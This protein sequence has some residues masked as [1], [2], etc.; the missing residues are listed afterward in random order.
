MRALTKEAFMDSAKLDLVRRPRRNRKSAGVRALVSETA[1]SI[2][3]LVYPV[4][5]CEGKNQERAIDSMKGITVKSLDKLLLELE[6]VVAL[7]IPAVAPFPSI[8]ESKKDARASIALSI[9]G[10]IPRT[11]REIKRA[12][13]DLVVMTDVALDPYNSEGHD[14]IVSESGEILNDETVSVLSQ[15]ALLHARA[16]ADFVCPSD[17]M[18]GR[19]GAIRKTLDLAGFQ[20]TSIMAY[21]AK[22]ASAFYG[23]F[24]EALGSSP[25]KLD[26]KTYQMDPSN[27]R[28]ALLEVE[29]DI[30]E[31]AD[32]VMVKPAGLYLDVIRRVA[33]VSCVPVSAYQVSGEYAMISLACEKGYLEPSRAILESLLA[34]KRA[35][36]DFIW[37]YF[38]KAAAAI[39]KQKGCL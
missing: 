18:D 28:E 5:V 29:L 6:E 26:K 4:F 20:N 22:Y 2:S 23:P 9:D 24:R 21:S 31:G 30:E 3:D 27:V 7:G 16:G 15:M 33:D 36:A 10:L 39:L 13:P 37:T 32:V 38:A 17:M 35:G 1:L 25:K 12:F 14:G 8:E 34:I 19:I 11:V